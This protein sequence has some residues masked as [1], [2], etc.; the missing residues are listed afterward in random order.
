[1][2]TSFITLILDIK[3]LK[4]MSEIRSVAIIDF[5]VTPTE[6][7]NVASLKQAEIF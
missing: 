6:I 3:L 1:M 5:H 2:L 7:Q 4:G